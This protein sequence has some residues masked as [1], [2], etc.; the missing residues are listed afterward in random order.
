M[1]TETEE[2]EPVPYRHHGEEGFHHQTSRS[3]PCSAPLLPP[4][5]LVNWRIA[6]MEGSHALGDPF[7]SDR[8]APAIST[9]H[10]TRDPPKQLYRSSASLQPAFE[11]LERDDL[12]EQD[13]VAFCQ[14]KIARPPPSRDSPQG[15][16]MDQQQAYRRRRKEI[17]TL[18]R[19][20]K[21]GDARVDEDGRLVPVQNPAPPP[22]IRL[23]PPPVRQVAPPGGPW[24]GMDNE[25][26]HRQ[27]MVEGEQE[28]TAAVARALQL[29]RA[30]GVPVEEIFLVQ[31]PPDEDQA[32]HTFRRVCFAVMAVVVAFVCIMLQTLPLSSPTRYSNPDK[33]PGELLHIKRIE[34]HA[35]TCP[36]LDRTEN[37]TQWDRLWEFLGR[38][39]TDD[40]ADGVLHVPSSRALMERVVSSRSLTRSVASMALNGVNVSWFL[41][42]HA[43]G[44]LESSVEATSGHTGNSDTCTGP[45][46]N[47]QCF[48]GIH[49]DF[50]PYHQISSALELGAR[51]ILEGGDHYDIRYNTK[52]LNENLGAIVS[53][54]QALLRDTYL[55]GDNIRPVA[56]R[57]GA[58]GPMDGTDVPR[59]GMKSSSNKPVKLLNLTNYVRYIERVSK[60]NS[61]AQFSLPW[62]LRVQ[63][64]RDECNLLADTQVEP[65]FAI[66]TMI[67]LSDG[68][69]S[70]FRGGEA[71]FVD[72]HPSNANPRRKIRRGV[73]IDGTR[74]RLV[75]STGGLENLRCRLPVR[76]GVRAALQIWW[77]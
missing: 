26:E 68:A 6:D 30:Q 48:R 20:V 5:F 4:S 71:L 35:Y 3:E 22:A 17:Q 33:L 8:L 72:H 18:R 75:V 2:N 31:V 1:T 54:V 23:D 53:K 24:G 69:G 7:P 63:S 45:E 46:A 57:L 13:I 56:F 58:E 51:L 64:Y 19:K 52:E 42:C 49:D 43:V 10:G 74:G 25:E 70:E 39:V 65:R 77:Q 61:Y 16:I 27:W 60:R 50:L 11:L 73:V 44:G 9:S 38:P 14:G 41:E 37:L 62:P 12:T 59:L 36:Q 29:Y 32:N 34:E 21:T 67:F 15:Q 40:C 47:K 66:H 28:A 76:A 55:V